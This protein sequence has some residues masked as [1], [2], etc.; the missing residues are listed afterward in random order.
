MPTS[1]G[2]RFSALYGKE[3]RELRP[4][5]IIIL[6]CTAVISLTM[7]S[8]GG[9]ERDFFIV[10]LFLL[11]GLA[12]FLPFISSFK[13]LNR[14]FS[15]NTIYFIMSLPVRGGMILSSK[16]LALLSQYVIG[17]L[18]VGAGEFLLLYPHRE[19]I[20]SF[21]SSALGVSG[22]VSSVALVLGLFYLQ[23][24]MQLSYALAISFLSQLVGKLTT[25]M[26]GLATIGTF[27]AVLYLG[28][29]IVY[30]LQQQF[31]TPLNNPAATGPMGG[32]TGLFI[33]SDLGVPAQFVTQVS[34]YLAVN[35]G[36]YFVLALVIMLVSIY[37]YNHRIEL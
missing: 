2:Q 36:I 15:S 37:V 13:L 6:V 22:S 18:A 24:V 20:D 34:Q 33:S 35:S 17:T 23:S 8:R 3:M 26:S 19:Q 30:L 14:E 21:L 10:P 1:N 28:S 29:K 5:I 25:R 12:A 11:M 9:S 7:F 27:L 4:E 31:L 16:Y 32:L